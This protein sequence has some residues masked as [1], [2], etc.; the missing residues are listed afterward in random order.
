MTF[1]TIGE[2]LLAKTADGKLKSRIATVFV[3]K[4]IIVTLPGIHATQR[5]AYL[6]M[7][8][9]Q[10]QA[11]GQPALT[12][13][14]EA[15]ELSHAVDLVMEDDN[16]LIRPDPTRMD[17]AFAADEIL[18]EIISKEQI[19]FLHVLD[20]RV[21]NAVKRRG[22]NW[23]ITPLPRSAADMQQMILGSRIG[24]GGRE[25]YYFNRE[26]GSRLLTCQ[27][28]AALGSLDVAE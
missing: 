6:Q 27:E 16:V 9:Q 5:A 21:R 25:I 18:Q 3:G 4:Q 10:R 2:P 1:R 7:I 20:S 11:V 15:A 26:T 12:E 24:V 14:E 8:N 28:F 13:Q 19:K 23:R 17:L 22:E